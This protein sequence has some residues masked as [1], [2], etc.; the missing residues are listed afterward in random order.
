MKCSADCLS[1]RLGHLGEG[2]RQVAGRRRDLMEQELRA[3]RE[4]EAYH[5][6]HVRGRGRM[7]SCGLF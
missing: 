2:A 4:E 6:A 7:R 1:V 5:M 3:R